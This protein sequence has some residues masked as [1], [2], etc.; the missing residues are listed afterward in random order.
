M[1]KIVVIPALN[2][3]EKLE[4]II[5]RSLELDNQVIV[6]NDGSEETYEPFFRELSKKVIVLT[7]KENQGKGETIKTALKYMRQELWYYDMIGICIMAA[8]MS[9]RMMSASYNYLMNCY[10]VFH[11]EK[12]MTTGMSYMML[13]IVLF[14]FNNLILDFFLK[15]LFIPLYVAKIM[16]EITLF[17]ISWTVQRKFIFQDKKEIHF[18]EKKW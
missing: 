14:V 18:I 6:V 2:P 5:N 7:H 1:E 9:A 17:I 3:D 10:F 15:W 8:N 16:T 13:A 11:E 12:K 4:N